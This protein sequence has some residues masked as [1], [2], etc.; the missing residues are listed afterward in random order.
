M[1]FTFG[2]YSTQVVIRPEVPELNAIS[3]G[4]DRVL[5]V[6]DNNTEQFA[7]AID[8]TVPRCVLA[9]GED[10]K[11]W[12][13]VEKILV[14]AQNAALGRDGLFIGVGGGVI[15]DMT[16]F[17]AS[18]YRR[19]ARLCIVS[20]TLLGMVDAAVGGKTGFDLFGMK[21][22]VGTFYPAEL[23]YMPTNVL[24]TL[25]EY[26]WKSGMAELIKTTIL[27]TDDDFFSL[28]PSL[29]KIGP[30]LDRVISRAVS[31]KG[32]I[33]ESDPQETGDERVLLNLGHTF[34]H[35]L[36]ASVGLGVLSHGEAVAW[37]IARACDLG[38]Y[39]NITPSAR[40][41]AIRNLLSSA[42]YEITAPHPVLRNKQAFWQ[43]L[44][45]D[46]KKRAGALRFI[47]PAAHGACIVNAGKIDQ[48]VL[49]SIISGGRHTAENHNIISARLTKHDPIGV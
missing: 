18:V 14:A 12:A 19:G 44:A 27:D 32:R 24:E 20:T 47:V 39:L 42:E 34:G 1:R 36:E 23:V 3:G 30:G 13:S 43:A 9:P 10:G 37:G 2:I 38:E 46:K 35:A 16:A 29:L 28:M 25:P 49:E 15:S 33:V 21:N 22:M 11:N 4:A 31:I 26:E 40:A 45:S 41:D 6:C 8:P 17:A 5:L 48:S 7:S